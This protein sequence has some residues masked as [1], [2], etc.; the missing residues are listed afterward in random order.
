MAATAMARP[1]FGLY[2]YNALSLMS[3]LAMVKVLKGA[4]SV[5]GVLLMPVC[6][7]HF[8]REPIRLYRRFARLA[9][10]FRCALK[11][12]WFSDGRL[13][14]CRCDGLPRRWALRSFNNASLDMGN[15]TGNPSGDGKC[16]RMAGT[17]IVLWAQEALRPGSAASISPGLGGDA[18]LP[19]VMARDDRKRLSRGDNG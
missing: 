18:V 15:R 11:R 7:H 12:C 4:L 6:K 10:T 14:L 16:F 3:E 19:R 1:R 8:R 13:C 17:R 5:G 9:G 2:P